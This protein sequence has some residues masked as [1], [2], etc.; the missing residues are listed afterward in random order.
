M[1]KNCTALIC[2]WKSV[3]LLKPRLN[4]AVVGKDE[5]AP[6]SLK[7]VADVRPRLACG[8]YVWTRSPSPLILELLSDKALGEDVR[9][10]EH[11]V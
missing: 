2:N 10:L 8:R 3:K 7:V 1:E 9:K 11:F 6:L 4:S 5:E